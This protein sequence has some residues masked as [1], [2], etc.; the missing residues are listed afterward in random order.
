M[1]RDQHIIDELRRF[2]RRICL[3]LADDAAMPEERAGLLIMA[4]NYRGEISDRQ[5]ANRF[6][7]TVP[8]QGILGCRS[9][10]RKSLF[11]FGERAVARTQD[12]VI[13]SQN[14]DDDLTP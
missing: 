3:E 12:P 4:N 8:T 9:I 1:G 13:K 6:A 5:R 14:K 11:F 7:N 2:E 10:L